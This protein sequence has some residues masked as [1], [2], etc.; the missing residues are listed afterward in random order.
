[1]KY[2]LQTG[3]DFEQLAQQWRALEARAVNPFFLSWYWIGTWMQVMQPSVVLLRG[4]QND[5]VQLLALFVQDKTRIKG[6]I[7]VTRLMLHRTGNEEQDQI[8]IEYNGLLHSQA[9]TTEQL[10]DAIRFLQQSLSWDELVI[11]VSETRQLEG[12]IDAGLSRVDAWEAPGYAIDLERVRQQG[13]DYLGSLSRNTRYQLGRARRALEALGAVSYTRALTQEQAL[14]W[15][16][17]AAVWHR[18]R[19]GD[20]S[21]QSGFANPVFCRF[22][23]ELIMAGFADGVVELCQL[24]LDGKPLAIQYN[25]VYRK[26]VYFY[27]SGVDYVDS[28]D[29][30]LKIGLLMHLYAI[31]LHLKQGSQTYDFMAG[32][33][34]YKRS[35]G[36]VAATQ[37][38]VRLRKP[39]LRYR[40]EDWGRQQLQRLRQLKTNLEAQQ[41]AAKN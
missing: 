7:P 30:R 6:F 18:Q 29:S 31:E 16:D 40:I 33:A 13:G 1:M 11:G 2:E 22:H 15:L 39:R 10:A 9:V 26:Q 4:V 24:A 38:L 32:D 14:Q 3:V 21:G 25:F 41:R 37:Y 34:R 12:I 8:W 35:L 20:K 19:W 5:S 17:Q 23:A 28:D 27:L 36:S